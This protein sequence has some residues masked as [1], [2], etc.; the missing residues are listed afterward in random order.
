MNFLDYIVNLV[1]PPRCAVCTEIMEMGISGNL[2]CECREKYENNKGII[3]KYLGDSAV[4]NTTNLTRGYSVFEYGDVKS[5][6]EHFKFKGFK[7]D[8]IALGEIMYTVAEKNFPYILQDANII[9]PVPVHRRRFKERGF[10][11]SEVLAQRLAEFSG[12]MCCYNAIKRVRYTAPQS[13]LHPDQ[14]LIN[15]KNAFEINKDFDVAGKKILLIDDIFT[16]G[17]TI[18]ECA[19]ILRNSGAE[20]VDFFTLSVALLK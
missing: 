18:N 6:I 14:R 15:I 4:K 16:T 10:N 7:N 5:S 19:G 2:C 20:Q 17:A 13:G 1:Y 11:Q 8:G 9:V 3:V 12:K